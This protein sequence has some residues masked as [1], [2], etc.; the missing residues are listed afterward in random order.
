[1][2]ER[3]GA[4]VQESYWQERMAVSP[5]FIGIWGHFQEITTDSDFIEGGLRWIMVQVGQEL[6]SLIQLI[7][8]RMVFCFGIQMTS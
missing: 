3:D 5:A 6:P 8:D 4:V 2:E 1:M 7:I